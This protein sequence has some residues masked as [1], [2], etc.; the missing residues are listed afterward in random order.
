MAALV[1]IDVSAVHSPQQLHLIL[2]DKLGFP[3]YYGMTWDAFDECFGDPE[4]APMPDVLRIVGWQLLSERLP[5]DAA[6]LRQ[7]IE[8]G[9]SSESGCRVEWGS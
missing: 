4:S 1:E 7:C 2:A 5:R 3:N 8:E 9:I 6:L